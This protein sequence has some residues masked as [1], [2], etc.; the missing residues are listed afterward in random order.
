MDAERTAI[1]SQTVAIAVAVAVAVAGSDGG[2]RV[3]GI[4]V[5]A[6]CFAG[7]FVVQWLAFVP[8]Y[9]MKSERFFD[10]TGSLTYVLVVSVAVLLSPPVDVRSGLLWLL[11]VVW[12]ARL[13]TFLVRR[14]HRAGK[15]DRFDAFKPSLVRFM[16]V[17]TIQGLWVNLTLAAALAAIT[18]GARSA[19]GAPSG[20]DALLVVGALVWLIGFSI[21]V[22]A[23]TQKSGFRAN[24]ANKGR[25]ISTGLWSWSRHPNYFGEI[26]L[27]TGIAII[28]A[29]V[30]QGWQWATLISPVFVFVLLTR[31]SGI[32][33]LERKA[34]ATWGGQTEYEAYKARTP[35]L[36]PRPPRR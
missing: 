34:D 33:M 11:V 3:A 15:D 20:P 36:V 17:W 25:F 31:V 26:V 32:P 8:A 6:L 10:L 16:N 1:V 14:I 28:A 29:P 2:E 19:P 22:V 9:L 18:S 24:P 23:D 35:A 13:G 4:P 12:A 5:F 30:L 27:W 7:A 21:E